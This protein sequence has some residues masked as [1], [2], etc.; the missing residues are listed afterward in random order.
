MSSAGPGFPQTVPPAAGAFSSPFP[1]ALFPAQPSGPQQPDGKGFRPSDRPPLFPCPPGG[2]GERTSQEY[3]PWRRPSELAPLWARKRGPGKPQ[4]CLC[5]LTVPHGHC[6]PWEGPCG[7]FSL[8]MWLCLPCREPGSGAAAELFLLPPRLFLRRPG[9]HQAGAEAPEPAGR[10]LHQP[11]HGERPGA[12]PARVWDG[13][14][15]AGGWGQNR[16]RSRG[17]HGTPHSPSSGNSKQGSV[18]S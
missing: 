18:G 10:D 3:V 15:H 4:T 6:R 13:A 11:L 12:V 14:F 7:R 17:P 9:T 8:G 16:P 5:P 2:P 1:P